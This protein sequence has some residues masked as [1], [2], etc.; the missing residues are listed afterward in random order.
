MNVPGGRA[1]ARSG[2]YEAGGDSAA[3]RTL[4]NAEIIV[5]DIA[6]DGVHVASLAAPFTTSGANAQV[7]VILEING[8]DIAGTGD[9]SAAT[10]EIFTYAFDGEGQGA[11][12]DV[13][14]ASV[15]I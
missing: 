9:P 8:S 5:N 1:I 7:P 13:S 14:S 2:Y 12:L 6:Q 15:S 10:L 11:R 3:E 4:S